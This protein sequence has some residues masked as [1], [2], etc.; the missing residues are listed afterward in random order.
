MKQLAYIQQGQSEYDPRL[1][2]LLDGSGIDPHEF[3]GLD[4]FSLTPF[5]VLAGAT[6]SADAHSH[7]TDLHVVGVRVEVDEELEEAFYV[8]LPMILA[9]AYVTEEDTEPNGDTA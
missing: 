3:L 1:R 9:D 5:F 4:Y 8:T 7:G 6:V 2:E